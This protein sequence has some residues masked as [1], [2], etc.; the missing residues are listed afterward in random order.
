[1]VNQLTHWQMELGLSVGN[2]EDPSA[3]VA[4]Q[5]NVTRGANAGIEEVHSPILGVVHIVK[6]YLHRRSC[7][8]HLSRDNVN[9]TIIAIKGDL[10]QFNFF[11]KL[12]AKL[13]ESISVAPTNTDFN[14]L[15]INNAVEVV[16]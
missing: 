14:P 2:T 16:R 8:N 12:A 7:R 5:G 6:N 10:C 11:A 1:M 3:N 15:W 13:E 9:H 4:H